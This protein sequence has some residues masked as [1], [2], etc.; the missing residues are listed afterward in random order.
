MKRVKPFSRPFPVSFVSRL[1]FS[2][3]RRAELLSKEALSRE[4][5]EPAWTVWA[6]PLIALNPADS[7]SRRARGRLGAVRFVRVRSPSEGCRTSCVSYCVVSGF[8]FLRSS[9][10]RCVGAFHLDNRESC[11]VPSPRSARVCREH[12]WVFRRRQALAL[13]ESLSRRARTPPLGVSSKDALAN[14]RTLE[15]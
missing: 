12:R 14:V 6:S 8:V 1:S 3:A 9:T 11:S 7:I 2:L 15:N 10:T 13:N 4:W 5:P